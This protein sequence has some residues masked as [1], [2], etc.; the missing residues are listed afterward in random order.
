MNRPLFDCATNTS[1]VSISKEQFEYLLG[2]MA[3]L[4]DR[5]DDEHVDFL[6]Q[7]ARIAFNTLREY[8]PRHIAHEL[9][10]ILKTESK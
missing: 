9:E 2:Q 10:S 5:K 6:I 1:C 3:L 7:K 4:F 8:S